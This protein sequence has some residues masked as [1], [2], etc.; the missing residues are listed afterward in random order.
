MQAVNLKTNHL[1]QAVGIDD[2]PLFLSW[3]CDGGVRQSAYEIE[4]AAERAVSWKSGKVQSSIMHADAPAAA[5]GSRV[6]GSWNI[7]LWDENDVPGPWASA[8]FETGLNADD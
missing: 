8:V 4:L 3:Q 2:G 7:R 5:G 6:R 1:T